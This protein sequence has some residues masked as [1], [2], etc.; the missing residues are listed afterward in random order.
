M[1]FGG[2]AAVV[3]T[4]FGQHPIVPQVLILEAGDSHAR[5]FPPKLAGSKPDWSVAGW[6]VPVTVRLAAKSRWRCWS[7]HFTK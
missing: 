1:A 7:K 4:S 2:I 3:P 5:S 6:S